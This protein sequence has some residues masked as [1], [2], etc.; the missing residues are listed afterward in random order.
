MCVS[1]LE[2]CVLLGLDWVEPMMQFSLHVTCSCIVHA[3]VPFHSHF[4]Y[5]LL[6]VLFYLSHSL[7]LSFSLSLS[8][9]LSRIVWTWHPSA[10]LLCPETLFIPRHHLLI[11]LLFMSSSMMRMPV[12][13]SR[14]TSPNVAFIRNAT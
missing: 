7:S 14:R 9:S 6:T 5:S 10:K 12:S 4:W 13:T 1:K 3:Y 11:L 2:P 8:L